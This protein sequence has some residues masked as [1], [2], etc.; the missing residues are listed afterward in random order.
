MAV[1]QPIPIK[2]RPQHSI[3]IRPHTSPNTIDQLWDESALGL[4]RDDHMNVSVDS[5][6]SGIG[7]NAEI[8]LHPDGIIRTLP[9]T[10][11]SMEMRSTV[12]TDSQPVRVKYLDFNKEYQDAIFILNGTTPVELPPMYRVLSAENYSSDEADEWLESQGEVGWT[13]QPT[14]GIV[15][16]YEKGSTGL[17]TDP[18]TFASYGGTFGGVVLN[19]ISMEK[20]FNSSYTIPKGFR[21]Y[22][23]Y[24]EPVLGKFDEV[25]FAIQTRRPGGPWVTRSAFQ[26][27]Q[28]Q[29]QREIKARF[30]QELT[31]I[32]VICRETAGVG[33]IPVSMSY[34]IILLK[35]VE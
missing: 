27:F 7:L 21:G 1:A 3:N 5:F 9:D 18:K 13:S 32:R 10:P 8:E 26:A 25:F 4:E 19:S 14:S 16:I 34:Q 35:E 15:T 22:P 11:V 31:D 12:L 23:I 33:N 28:N 24:I 6:H 2:I 30:I 29:F 17:V 20:S